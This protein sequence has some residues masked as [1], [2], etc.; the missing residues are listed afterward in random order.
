MMDALEKCNFRLIGLRMENCSSSDEQVQMQ[1]RAM[2]KSLYGTNRWFYFYDGFEFDEKQRVCKVRKTAFD[3]TILY[4][5]G[6]QTISVSAIVGKNGTGKSTIVDMLIR[7]LNNLS[8]SILG[9]EE[10]YPAAE[11]LHFIDHVYASLAAYCDNVIYIIEAKGRNLTIYSLHCADDEGTY[12][13]GSQDTICV[14]TSAQY[15]SNTPIQPQPFEKQRVLEKL[16]YTTLFNYSLYAYNYRDYK[17]ES[18]PKERINRI[19]RFE[20]SEEDDYYWLK[21]VFH[22]NDGYQTPIVLNPMRYDGRLDSVKENAL[23]KERLLNLLYY[24]DSKNEY[25]FRTIN[26]KLRVVGLNLFHSTNDYN[27]AF[28][29]KKLG[30]NNSVV[31]E[32][33]SDY[34]EI[35][36]NT[37]AKL[38]HFEYPLQFGWEEATCNYIVYKTIKIAKQ[39]AKY[40]LF[41]TTLI[42]PDG[43][44]DGTIQKQIEEMAQDESHVTLK[45]RRALRYM[46]NIPVDGKV[47]CG[48][49]TLD[50]YY[51]EVIHFG[52]GCSIEIDENNELRS[53][54]S[55]AEFLPPPTISFDFDIV[56]SSCV[57][58]DGSYSKTD[59]I[60]FEGLSAGERQ[61]TYSITNFMY[62]LTNLESV[63]QDHSR[64]LDHE[65]I[66]Y[67][68]VNVV[69]D[70]LELYFHPELQRVFIGYLLKSIESG[71]FIHIRG[72]NILIVTHSPFVL[73][74]IPRTNVLAL[75]EKVTQKETFC[76]NIHEMLGSSFFMDYSIGELAQKT[77]EDI[78][79]CYRNFSKAK[80]KS[81]FVKDKNLTKFKFV[82]S[83]VADGYL[84][85][86][87]NRMVEEMASY[88]PS[89]FSNLELEIKEAQE[90]V[91][92]LLEE[93]KRREEHA[94]DKL[95]E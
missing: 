32:K 94:K 17:L 52:Q 16:F 57:K 84:R 36:I 50:E 58:S 42:T 8:A 60:P 69:F 29:I 31:D 89:R 76:A 74:D 93:K 68:N 87:A 34:Y 33:Y 81:K 7:V 72:I 79:N 63:W 11:H 86:T 59:I 83:K 39:Y 1:V 19:Y 27:S 14:L 64:Q 15:D 38:Y 5:V 91:E 9:E 51:N 13:F 41:W 26:D 75:G 21:G 71:N 47:V 12:V 23:A 35:I 92:Q 73:S 53:I 40:S 62:H 77:I 66:K 4:N 37:W 45:L 25:P 61:I 95:W 28:V 6:Q 65:V 46:K 88:V 3:D 20:Q 78:F 55:Q 2:Q 48:H 56:P 18:T 80:D 54:A 82:A 24:Q 49:R 30:V 10:I 43:D 67:R 22:K 90:R 44:M 70:E 85:K